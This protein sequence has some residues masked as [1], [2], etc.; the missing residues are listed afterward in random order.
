MFLALKYKNRIGT[1]KIKL[2]TIEFEEGKRM[3]RGASGFL[4]NSLSL[5]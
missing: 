2:G 5:Q 1:H 3:G 4:I